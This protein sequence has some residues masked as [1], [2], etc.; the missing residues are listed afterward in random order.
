M[1]FKYRRKLNNYDTKKNIY[2]CFIESAKVL[3]GSKV[4]VW[5]ITNCGKL[6]KRWEYQTILPIS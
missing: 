4:F 1:L 6:L 3:C 2:L 5:I